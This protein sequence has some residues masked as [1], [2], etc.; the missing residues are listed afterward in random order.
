VHTYFGFWCVGGL[1]RS[2]AWCWCHSWAWYWWAAPRLKG[3]VERGINNRSF[4]PI[5]RPNRSVFL[6]LNNQYHICL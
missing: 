6:F 1:Q 5:G 2:W 3:A 4:A